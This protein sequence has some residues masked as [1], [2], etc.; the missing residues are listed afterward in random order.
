MSHPLR[1]RDQRH[2]S[3][4]I[5]AVS[6]PA[7][8]A[9]RGIVR[10]SGPRAIDVVGGL[11]RW[12]W[13]VSIRRP[14]ETKDN[15][16]VPG[17]PPGSGARRLSRAGNYV[18]VQCALGLSS[19]PVAV[20]V[21]LY[22]MKA[23]T[24][25]TREDIVEIHTFGSPPLLE[26]V[27]EAVL[28]REVRLADPGEFTRRAFLNGRIDLA[29]AEAVLAVIR[30]TTDAELHAAT[31]Q[32]G[33]AF[34]DRMAAVRDRILD[35]CVRIEAAIDFSDQDIEIIPARDASRE[36]AHTRSEV[37][38]ILHSSASSRAREEAVAAV[39]YGPANAGK[40]SLFN[41]ILRKATAIVSPV[42]GTTR[43][44]L[45][46]AVEMDGVRFR[47]VDTAGARSPAHASDAQPVEA[48]AQERTRH[49]V[50]RA[51]MVLLVLDASQALGRAEQEMLRSLT[52]RVSIVL[53]NKNDLAPRTRPED[54]ARVCTTAGGCDAPVTVSVSALAGQGLDAVCREMTEKVWRGDLDRSTPQFLL[55][56]RQRES[57]RGSAAALARAA[58]AADRDAG[59]E[60]IALDLREALDALGEV[61]GEVAT[62]DILDRIFAEFCIGK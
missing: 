42:P 62:D 21:E 29:Q 43:D 40:S 16:P 19:C 49:E 25:Y 45:Q 61:V 1:P 35:L 12:D 28:S 22:V 4:T 27:L 34:S 59:H 53:L 57:L 55:N 52:P 46:A 18:S 33:G 58:D 20:P 32:L 50:A 31:R 26:E 5:A 47:L 15:L 39:L 24:S 10:L 44:S 9:P 37:A 17:P 48:R 23:P 6:T 3:D 36:I 41:A 11:V 51:E 54:V 56:V 13:P 30:S 8:A 2:V 60:F 7:G 14:P 38:D